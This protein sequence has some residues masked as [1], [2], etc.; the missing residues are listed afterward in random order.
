M[1]KYIDLAGAGY[2]EDQR[3]EQIGQAA[4]AGK[5]VA[6]V[7]DDDGKKADRYIEKL[8]KHFPKLVV[9][10]RGKGPTRGAY[11]VK[12]GLPADGP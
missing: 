12:V 8:K 1:G 7:V 5:T 10:F 4:M 3:I 6:F 9:T 11:T 2:K